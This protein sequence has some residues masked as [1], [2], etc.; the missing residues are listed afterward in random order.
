[1]RK[2]FMGEGYFR[3]GRAVKDFNAFFMRSGKAL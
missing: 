2:V 1:L 3:S